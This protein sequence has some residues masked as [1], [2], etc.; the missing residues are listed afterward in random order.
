MR[1]SWRGP[2]GA[3]HQGPPN[4]ALGRMRRSELST[5]QCS[6]SANNSSRPRSRC[7]HH[8]NWLIVPPNFVSLTETSAPRMVVLYWGSCVCWSL[9]QSLGAKGL[10]AL[11]RADQW[12]SW[13]QSRAERVQSRWSIGPQPEPS[14]NECCSEKT[15]RRWLR[16]RLPGLGLSLPMERR[17]NWPLRHSASGLPTFSTR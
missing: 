8:P 10:W 12:R 1:I 7:H 6:E 2:S 16:Q 14:R 9:K 17:S 5:V 15:S 11:T 13:R 3:T 4:A